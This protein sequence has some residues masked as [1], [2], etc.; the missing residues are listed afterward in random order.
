MVEFNGEEN[1]VHLL[2]KFRPK[3]A[4]AKLVNSLKG[5]S[6]RRP[7]QEFPD[8]ARHYY[9]ANHLWSASYFAGSLGGASLSVL[10]QYIEQQN[11]PAQGTL[12]P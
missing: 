3:L 5:V 2:V 11:R 10:R 4:L 12:G 7:R 8:L 9:R 1:H 6:S